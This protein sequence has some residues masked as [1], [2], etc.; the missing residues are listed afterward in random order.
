MKKARY[1][2][3]PEAAGQLGISLPTLYAY[4]SRG[5]IR[6]EPAGGRRRTRRYYQEDVQ[7]LKERKEGRRNPDKVA[8]GALHT[9]APVLE[10]AITLITDDCIYYRGRNALE[11]ATSHGIEQVA[12]LIWTGDLEAEIFDFVDPLPSRCRAMYPQLNDLQP[13]ETLQIL[14]PLAA[15]DDL[16]AYD[17]SSQAVVR[18]GARIMRLM[19]AIIAG[20]L[21]EGI[22]GARTL[23]QAWAPG[24][25]KAEAVL[26]A[27]LVLCA[28][29]ELNASAFTARCVAS[30]G[31]T[32][33][34]VVTAGLAALQ[35]Y[36]H[37]GASERVWETFFREFKNRAQVRQALAAHLKQGGYIPGFGHAV[38]REVDPRARTLLQLIGEAY[39]TSPAVGIA[40]TVIEEVSNLLSLHYNLDL[41]LATLTHTLN[42]PPGGAIALFALGRSIGWIGHAI[43]QYQAN[44]LIRPR[45]RYVGEQPAE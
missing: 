8:Q 11:L 41:A 45:A 10:S 34:A 29:H 2:T 35:G 9:G 37:G 27:V 43:E 31:S 5:L 38:Y 33:Y 30:T 25:P 23:K 1:L 36:K 16:A 18:T 12:A 17:L 39:P 21:K 44:R 13:L 3:A 19:A 22:P 14:L 42:L 26:N 6:S 20:N 4:V 28:D 24:D 32:P 7:Q 15:T 40:R